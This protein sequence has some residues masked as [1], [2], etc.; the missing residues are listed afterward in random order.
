MARE[1]RFE[2]RTRRSDRSRPLRRRLL[3]VTQG[4]VTEPVY[5]EALKRL[6]REVVVVVET[7]PKSPPQMLDAAR[8]IQIKAARSREERYDTVW[9]VFDAEERPD[10]AMLRQLRHQADQHGIRLAWSN[11]CFEVWLT[12]HLAFSQAQLLNAAESIRQLTTH[13]PSYAKDRRGAER[14]MA[15]LL[16]LVGTALVNAQR[17][18]EGHVARDAGEFPNPATDIDQLVRDMIQENGSGGLIRRST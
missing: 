2:K 15:I 4:E 11:P 9:V 3:V 17:L 13:L 18:R 10:L 12:L 6:H 8:A 14:N 7:C 5:F 16:P 1:V